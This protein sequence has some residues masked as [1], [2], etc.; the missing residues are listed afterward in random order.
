MIRSTNRIASLALPIAMLASTRTRC[1]E[2]TAARTCRTA[3][4]SRSRPCPVLTLTVRKPSLDTRE[5]VL[6]HLL[7]LAVRDRVAERDPVAHLA[8]EQ[9]I[10]TGTPSALP[11]MSQSA[12]STPAIAS[13]PSGSA[14]LHGAQRAR[15]CERVPADENGAEPLV[16]V[17]AQQRTAAGEHAGQLAQTGQPF[18]GVDPGRCRARKCRRSRARCG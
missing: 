1:A 11:A 8:A 7:R 17:A 13:W 6:R 16:D 9:S 10:C 2:P 4:M 12:I 3:S 15:D 18:V 14:A 5:R